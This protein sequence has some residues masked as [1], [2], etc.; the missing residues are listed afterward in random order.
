MEH[1]TLETGL[2]NLLGERQRERLLYN[3]WNYVTKLGES[4]EI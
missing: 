3:V 4:F 2:H 1:E